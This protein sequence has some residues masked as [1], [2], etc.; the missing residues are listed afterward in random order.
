MILLITILWFL[1]TPFYLSSQQK[2]FDFSG[3]FQTESGILNFLSDEYKNYFLNRNTFRF[4]FL[5]KKQNIKLDGSIDLHILATEYQHLYFSSLDNSTQIYDDL[6][7][8]TN[9]RKLYC[10]LKIK[11]F[12]IYIGRQLIKFGEGTIFSPLDPFSK[13]DFNDILLSRYGIDAIRT[14]IS[15]SNTEYFE[16]IFLPKEN[17]KYKDITSRLG[18]TIYNYDIS[19]MIYYY[20]KS[21][22]KSFGFSFKGDLLL[23]L[24]GEYIYYFKDDINFYSYLL[25]LDYSLYQKIIFKAEFYKNN[26]DNNIVSIVNNFISPFFSKTYLMLQTIYTLSIIRSI[27]FTYIFNLDNNA[28]LTILAYQHNIYQNIDIIFSLRHIYKDISG[29]TTDE[30]LQ[31][32]YYSFGLKIRF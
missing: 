10:M 14:K 25:G 15:L 3:Y 21:N 32:I 5:N 8:L 17:F 12:D 30:N 20:N 23:G 26:Y 24:Y 27:Y 7:L 31:V 22:I 28:N 19:T 11:N 1:F 2:N 4:N 9:L 16:T 18:F 6:Y 29:F 13:I